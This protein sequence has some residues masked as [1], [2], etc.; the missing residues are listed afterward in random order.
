MDHPPLVKYWGVYIPPIPPGI[1]A[2]VCEQF[3]ISSKKKFFLQH[4]TAT[5]GGKVAMYTIITTGAMYVSKNSKYCSHE[6]WVSLVLQLV[7]CLV[8]T[9][10]LVKCLSTTGKLVKCYQLVIW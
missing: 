4:T 1:Y 2:Y 7:G 3:I 8:T 10:N 9:G 5:N 6:V